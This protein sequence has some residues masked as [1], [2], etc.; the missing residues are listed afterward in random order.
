M[1]RW[2]H[3]TLSNPAPPGDLNAGLCFSRSSRWEH[4]GLSSVSTV[5]TETWGCNGMSDEHNST[6][7]EEPATLRRLETF[8]FF[9]AMMLA[10]ILDGACACWMWKHVGPVSTNMVDPLCEQKGSVLREGWLLAALLVLVCRAGETLSTAKRWSHDE[11]LQN[12]LAFLRLWGW[13][14]ALLAAQGVAIHLGP[15]LP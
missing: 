12:Q 2:K 3:P 7:K 15:V 9:L 6:R 10:V 4:S 13:A 1:V 11:V 14:M 5:G 8:A